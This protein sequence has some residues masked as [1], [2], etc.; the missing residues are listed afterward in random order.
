MENNELNEAENT[1]FNEN[2]INYYFKQKKAYIHDYK[3]IKNIGFDKYG[4][5]LLVSYNINELL[6]K[7]LYVMEKIEVK[8]SKLKSEIIKKMDVLKNI[9][10]KYINKV[11]DYY[12]VNEEGKCFAFILMDYCEKGD[13]NQIIYETNY[14]NQRTI[15]RIFIQIVQ[16]LKSLF[17][18]NIILKSLTT[19]NIL[20]DKKNNAKIGRFDI[21]YD[22]V[23]EYLFQENENL[24]SYVSPEIL[25]G[26][27]YTNKCIV[28]SLGCILYELV[29][30]NKAFNYFDNNIKIEIQ[31][32]EIPDN[33]GINF[34]IFLSKLLCEE[35]NRLTINEIIY[36]GIVKN[37]LIDNNL[38]D[39]ILKDKNKVKGK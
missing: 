2:N 25:N 15:W 29:F 39:E 5:L 31:R 35:Q 34:K 16:G 3:L 36:N 21:I 1:E 8:S 18:N 10:S 7:K 13:L 6:N 14:L 17:S 12:F 27:P 38:F 20:I 24:L 4:K 37:Q 11:Y 28:W 9:N 30:K 33:C 22:F 23:D 26:L 19:L 32:F